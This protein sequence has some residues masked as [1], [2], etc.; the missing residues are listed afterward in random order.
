[1][2]VRLWISTVRNASYEEMPLLPVGTDGLFPIPGDEHSIVSFL[3][4]VLDID[5][6]NI[7][8]LP[9]GGS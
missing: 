2:N 1:M 8:V 9:S 3:F 7:V 4:I 6:M 5:C